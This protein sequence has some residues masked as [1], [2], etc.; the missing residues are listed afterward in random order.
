MA[1]LA[2]VQFA[3]YATRYSDPAKLSRKELPDECQ[4]ALLDIVDDLADDPNRH[5]GRLRQLFGE[6]MLYKHPSPP[7]EITFKLDVD[8]QEIHF[9]HFSAPALPVR[10]QL[11]VSYSHEDARWLEEIKGWLTQLEKQ[12]LIESWDDTEIKPGARWRD[13]IADALEAAQMALFLV[14]LDFLNS[15][16]I[17]DEELPK[18]LAAARDSGLIVLCVAISDCPYEDSPLA[19]FQW[20]HDPGKPLDSFSRK[21]DRNRAL[22]AIYEKIKAAASE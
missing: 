6:V 7:L 20:L 13:A 22:K 15:E 8:E 4:M 2:E 5:P 1:E 16:F 12:G 9:L 18:L 17:N 11:F 21:A 3:A 19:E 10:R 14:S